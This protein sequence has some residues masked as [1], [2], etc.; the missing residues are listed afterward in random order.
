MIPTVSIER[1][2]ASHPIRAMSLLIAC[3]CLVM[4]FLMMC[5]VA[6]AADY[7]TID[8]TSSNCAQW[9]TD[10]SNNV[11]IITGNIN[12][13]SG[14]LHLSNAT[15]RMENEYSI[16]VRTGATMDV[17][18]GSMITHNSSGNYY[19]TYYNGSYGSLSASIIEYSYKLGIATENNITITGCTI[20]NNQNHGIHLTSTSGYVSI[21][22]CVIS[23]TVQQ[24]GIFIESSQGNILQ[25]NNLNNNSGNY[26]LYVTGNYDQ[27][28]D[29]SNNVNGGK[30]YYNY[31]DSS[32][33][34]DLDIGHV[35]IVDHSNLLF[36]NCIIHNGDGVRIRGVSSNV[37]IRNSIIENNTVHGINFD[38]TGWNNITFVTIKNNAKQGVYFFDSSYNFINDCHILDNP[39]NG[40]HSDGTSNYNRIINNNIVNNSFG[41]YLSGNGH[42]NF[43]DNNISD[44]CVSGIS[45]G[46]PDSHSSE[47]NILHNNTIMSNNVS[48][49]LFRTNNN[50]LTN[51]TISDNKD[52]AFEFPG[53][54]KYYYNYIGRSNKANGEEINYYYNENGNTIQ[55]KS[56][57]AYNVSN[58][59]KIT[60]V[61]CSNFD[62]QDNTLSNNIQSGSGIFLWNSVNN[63][64]ADNTLSN[65]YDGIVL[66]NS[67]NN[68]FTNMQTT[69]PSNDYG[70]FLLDS[71]YNSITNSS[72]VATNKNGLNI[73]SSDHTTLTNIMISSVNQSG[74]N[75]LHAHYIDITN[76]KITTTEADGAYL[77]S[78]DNVTIKE[79][80]ITANNTGIYFNGSNH[81]DLIN[82]T[83][84]GK[85]GICMSGSHWGN[86]TNNTI[87]ATLKGIFLTTS[88]DHNLTINKITKYTISGILLEEYSTNN[89][90]IGNDLIRNGSKFDIRIND[91][92][93]AIIAPNNT[94]SANYTFH[95]T[96]DT[97]LCTLDTV[98]NKTKICYEDTSNLTLMWRIDV[99]CWDNYHNEPIWTN[100]T[101]RYR[102]IS[103]YNE[104]LCWEG[105]TPNA[106]GRLS[107]NAF[108]DYGPPTSSSNWL[109]IIEYKQNVS[110]KTT[111][112]PMNCTAVNRWD[113]LN[114][115][116]DQSYKNITT[117][118]SGP[119][120]TILVDAG[121]TPNGKC[122]YCHNDKLIYSDGTYKFPNTIHWIK[123]NE[124]I[125]DNSQD[126]PYT[127]GRCIDCHDKND[128]ENIPHGNTSGKDLLYQPSPQLCYNG[129]GTQT[130][131]NS[132]E[133]RATLNQKEEFNKTTH[134]PLG[135]GKL[136]CKAC[137]D[138]HGSKHRFDL[139]RYY[140]DSTSASYNSYNFALCLVCHL[141]E[142]LV[143]KMSG[144]TGHLANYMNQ[145][146]FRDEYYYA[147]RGFS[148]GGTGGT[149]LFKNIHSPQTEAN[150]YDTTHSRPNCY[151]CHNPHGSDNPAT[152][153]FTVG[154]DVFNYTYITDL[155]YPGN[156]WT[157]LDQA[158]WNNTT[159][160][161]GGG[162][163]VEVGDGCS[164]HGSFD[165]TLQTG[166]FTYRE[167]ID[168]EPAGGAGCLECHDNNAFAYNE[169]PIRPIVNLTAVK[170]AMHS[171][172]SGAFC[173]GS[174]LQGTDRNF[175]EWLEN[176]TY[177]PEQINN[178]SKDNAICWACHCT[179]GT[180][181]S[182]NFHPD[183]A[184]NPYK[185]PK[186]HGPYD[187]QPP[188][189]QGLVAA[190][191]NHGPTTKGIG[192]IFIQ[193]D[194]GSN[195]SCG[196]CHA[197][198]RLSDDDIGDLKVWKWGTGPSGTGGGEITYTGTTTMGNVS[199][200]GLNRSQGEALNIE[201]PLLDTSDC[202][203]CHCNTTNGQIWGNAPNVTNNMYGANTS[204]L[205]ECYTYCHVLPNYLNDVTE[206]NI[207]HFHN[208]SIY[209][210]GG[211]D[212]VVCHDIN[213]SYGVQ[214]LVDAD[215]IATGI[216]GNVTNNTYTD[217]LECDPRSNPCWGCHNSNGMQPEGMGDRNF[218][219][220][221]QK[222]PWS[223]EDC[224]GRSDEWNAA[225]S[226]GETW[227]SSSYP[228]NRLPPII[229]AHYPNSTTLKTN[230]IGEGSCMDCHNN[231]INQSHV[232]TKGQILNNTLASNISHYGT[233][234]DLINPTEDCSI[235]HNTTPEN[236]VKWGGA[237]QNKHGN[238]TDE[239]NPNDG[240]FVCHTNDNQTPVDLHAAN[241]WSG[242]GGPECLECHDDDG[243]AERRR[244]NESVY[245]KSNHAKMNNATT[246]PYGMNQS[247]WACHFENGTNADNHSM[248]KDPPYLCHE[249]HNKDGG[250]SNNVSDAPKVH[251]HFK[252]GT[253]I[254]A[255][256][257]MPTDLDTCMRCHNLSEMKY[258]FTEN[259]TY[260]TVFSVVSH[261]GNNRT[262]LVNMCE[263]NANN[264]EY[265]SYCHVN[266]TPFTE[267]DNIIV[268]ITHAGD[269]H[270]DVC[271][272]TG[273]FHSNNV[274]RVS[275]SGNCTDCHALY[276]ANKTK[277]IG[278]GPIEYEINVTAMNLGVH[279]NVNEN[280]K[281]VA[282]APPINDPNNSMCWG[283]HV[284]GGAY[285]ETGHNETF[286]ND[287]YLC[288]ECHNGT[289]A[290][291]NVN[292]ATAVY[293]H[294]K[295][296]VNIVAN[297][298]A[299]T[300]STSCGLGCHN[301]DTMKVPG[302]NAG[303]KASYR[304]NM[305]Q[306]SHYS[307]S[308]TDII[309]ASDLSDCTWCHR[310]STNEF[311]D[312]FVNAG[313]PN[314]TANITH[315][316]ETSGCI[317]AA[318]HNR[319]RIHDL[320]LT[321]PEL[322]WSEEC[323][324]CH[325]GLNDSNAYVNETM[326]SS[327]VHRDMDC[328]DC[329]INNSL[330]HPVEEY[331]WKWCECCHSYQTDPINEKD[332]HNVTNT[333]STYSVGGT[334]VLD[335]TDCTTCHNATAYNA[336]VDYY[337]NN[338]IATDCR[339]CHVYP[340]KGNRTS[341]EWY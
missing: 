222:K 16:N 305:S 31:T 192:S 204:N 226:Y 76:A 235:C 191:D 29:T 22:G 97:R 328:I 236:A 313:S 318:C 127:P 54:I 19:Y 225:T 184:L 153:R 207:L 294:F 134:H 27:D 290:Y 152:T 174:D 140:K 241:L 275:T 217:I 109:P 255:Y 295:S 299:E 261:Y 79:S 202:L 298:K 57:T 116:Y 197:P 215:A 69:N 334:N 323:E 12:V 291:P 177:T 163:Y 15:I 36:T 104:S 331:S 176:R 263:N 178:I 303:G 219:Y 169:T 243:F 67:P 68:N 337:T 139:L 95:L 122:Y 62:I 200:Y 132:S 300:N 77:K 186:C 182:P 248:R 188:H 111:Y 135:D 33:I 296:G 205:S 172:L 106:N 142:K 232:D 201:N 221:P 13:N 262:D 17:T 171:N 321:I 46:T 60:L 94:V 158:N 20:R 284:P 316:T 45:L 34:S 40:I 258:P 52:L 83:I 3:I 102:D 75:T 250:P 56:L 335:I 317:V 194:V 117:V 264:T 279:V 196:D 38:S 74:L 110:T 211:F 6:E 51:N 150:S 247:C 267:F 306:T 87:D 227:I 65:N 8:I 333:P 329:H 324:G 283:C 145:T 30:V 245:E 268:N 28:I 5:Q 7:G 141:E 101:V 240:C 154:D 1:I 161:M 55:L 128:S 47:Y 330:F 93:D 322:S 238:F 50:T 131:H 301:L 260:N 327:S 218:I 224:H 213:S 336:T 118:I 23:N 175:T 288:Y 179:N 32:T 82:N 274:T 185:C 203:F 64:L 332:R 121:H 166:F 24:H 37:S 278:S 270:C 253:S 159:A 265:C 119:G 269:T 312:I 285:P 189:T 287:A 84:V 41:L 107:N 156:T 272:G 233:T 308:R 339:Y 108:G 231:S 180:P 125:M 228:S 136:A 2:H 148:S 210:G 155:A 120:V 11:S 42:N 100:L 164:C 59:G 149:K 237:L 273:R 162:L 85:N 113:V 309:L 78:S 92:I 71:D 168:Y 80:D 146:N 319:G 320:N 254:Q 39:G 338:D 14:V 311:I 246:G 126:D 138:N 234:T 81:T 143:A 4:I 315:A 123:Y 133:V 10:L 129:K 26:S 302:F 314:Y 89:T 187:G 304:V 230:I 193:T 206:D 293:N 115:M 105:E 160:N 49:I 124:S 98:F 151:S 114:Q 190:I 144:E 259:D 91:S 88:R 63:D 199:H 257:T 242:L 239:S 276:G 157:V 340:D 181:P 170:L 90:M 112:Q 165:W 229:H 173:T 73:E 341:Q 130:C 249:C 214:S 99:L 58:V 48:G 70:A 18:D 252:N 72:L 286:N 21:T 43:T 282:S 223:C 325:F 281:S 44:N 25:N 198:S 66:Y 183:R 209:S 251:N 35:T 292:S 61:N 220:R 310:N 266:D 147:T 208:K 280:M 289:Y 96:N 167:F 212:C 271:H 137:H 326:F 297:T 86:L 195:G 256:W 244:I 103:D 53:E 277:Y 307:K 216:H 9:S